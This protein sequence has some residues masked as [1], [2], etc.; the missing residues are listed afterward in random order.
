MKCFLKIEDEGRLGVKSDQPGSAPNWLGKD[1]AVVES[2]DRI[3][4]GND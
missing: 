4:N 1:E 3:S 2:R